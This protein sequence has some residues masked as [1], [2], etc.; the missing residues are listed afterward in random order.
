MKRI[1]PVKKEKK[2]IVS[3]VCWQEENLWIKTACVYIMPLLI[4]TVILDM[5]L[6]SSVPHFP[7]LLNKGN[8]SSYIIG[9]LGN[10]NMIIHKALSRVV[11]T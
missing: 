7:H 1:K 8:N 5:L 4:L 10:L 11:G 9:F 3:M 6:N 2:R